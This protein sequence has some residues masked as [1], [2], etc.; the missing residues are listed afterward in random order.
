[1]PELKLDI[2]TCWWLIIF[3]TV[4]EAA[5]WSLVGCFLSLCDWVLGVPQFTA[6]NAQGYESWDLSLPVSRSV[7]EYSSKEWNNLYQKIGVLSKILLEKIS[8]FV[9]T[10]VKLSNF[11]FSSYF[12]VKTPIFFWSF[13][14]IFPPVSR[15]W[16]RVISFKALSPA[17]T[18]CDIK[19]DCSAPSKPQ[20]RLQFLIL[21]SLLH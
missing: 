1:M 2:R 5:A 8:K 16:P 15:S 19:L 10:E 9:M 21:D 3:I 13:C 4:T 6:S 14:K 20:T 11:P 12:L 17:Q 18:R 7:G